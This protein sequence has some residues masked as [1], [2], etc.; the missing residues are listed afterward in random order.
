[1]NA[2]EL[3]DFL[4]TTLCM[5][6]TN[7]PKVKNKALKNGYLITKRGIG[8][9]A[10][11]E[12]EKVIPQNIPFEP[13]FKKEQ[14]IADFNGEKWVTAFCNNDYEVSNYGRVRN[15][16]DLT[17]RKASDSYE[18][19]KKVSID[20]KNYPLHRLILISFNPIQ[21]YQ[22]FQVDHINGNRSD[23]RLENL[24]WVT[25][26]ENT[27]AMLM[28]RKELNKEL[29]RLLSNHSYEEVLQ[30]LQNLK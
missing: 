27:S 30:M 28:N 20:G 19:Y 5:V 6:K 21:N 17:L 1:M 25:N 4:Q 8:D 26:E 2:Q 14:W 13:E 23:N 29:T 22:Y 18:L 11:Y 9:K 10:I 3:A 16:K 24:R 12:V 7:F 15:K